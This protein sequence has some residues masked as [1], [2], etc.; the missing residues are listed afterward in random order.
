MPS[1]WSPFSR[2][3][4]SYR[5]PL[6]L[7]RQLLPPSEITTTYRRKYFFTILKWRAAMSVCMSF[8][9]K[10]KKKTNPPIRL[11]QW[12][13]F[14]RIEKNGRWPRCLSRFCLHIST[15]HQSDVMWCVVYHTRKWWWWWFPTD[16]LSPT[17]LPFCC[18]CCC[19]CSPLF[20]FLFICDK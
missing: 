18:C 15:Q 6:Q 5:E 8:Y 4:L 19:C 16:W 7:H 13:V 14:V 17:R 12:S 3:A 1:S 11:L 9:F 10:K 2:C 20:I